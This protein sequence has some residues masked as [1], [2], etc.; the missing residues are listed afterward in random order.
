VEQ[1]RKEWRA[2]WDGYPADGSDVPTRISLFL[3]FMELGRKCQPRTWSQEDLRRLGEMLLIICAW[4]SDDSDKN[5][6]PQ[7]RRYLLRMLGRLFVEG[8]DS[9]VVKD[10]TLELSLSVLPSLTQ[11]VPE[12]VDERYYIALSKQTTF[13]G[14]HDSLLQSL[15]EAVVV[16]LR[17]PLRPGRTDTEADAAYRAFNVSYLTTPDLV[18]LLGGRATEKLI[19]GVDLRKVTEFFGL[20]L[21]TESKL[22]L[23]SHVVYFSRH[24]KEVVDLTAAG[25]LT[26]REEYIKFLSMAL[27]SVA[28]EVGQRIDVE[29]VAMG[30]GDGSDDEDGIS[31][32]RPRVRR[33]PLPPFVKQQIESLV[34]QSSITSLLS[35]TKSTDGNVD[36]LAGFALT[37][38]LVFPARRTDMRF[39]LCVA[40]TADGAPAVK[41]VWNAMKKCWLFAS[42]KRDSRAAVEPLKRW[43]TPPKG[44]SV[45]DIE[46]QWNLIFLFLEMYSFVLVT[47][48]DHEFMQGKGRQ[49]QLNEVKELTLFLKNLSFATYWWYPEIMDDHQTKDIGGEESPNV[50]ENG[51]AWDM[52][53]FRSVVTDV[54]K[55]IYA[56]E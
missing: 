40:L 42:I 25:L 52:N 50:Q 21:E 45:K 18:S 11:N 44:M 34:Q 8:I 14:L 19:A 33:Q 16:P 15:I 32:K 24:K 28:V 48:D 38:L 30:D 31:S 53:Y 27:S 22:W 41:Y 4:L 47:G 5:C 35:N 12:L 6:D 26:D 49:L 23:L 17:V 54:L 46:D 3:A 37:L 55:A 56:R 51:R 1:Q 7:R 9:G 36:I 39:W 29:D 13:S 2:V 10:E 43:P 20:N